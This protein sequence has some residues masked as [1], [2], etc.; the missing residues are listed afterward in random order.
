L[1]QDLGKVMEVDNSL[2]HIYIY[3]YIYIYIH[4][5]IYIYIDVDIDIDTDTDMYIDAD[6][7]GYPPDEEESVYRESSIVYCLEQEF[8]FHN[9][10]ILH[11]VCN[12]MFCYKYCSCP[13]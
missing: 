11:V 9:I 1:K 4:T 7:S 10:P 2:I 12:H 5:Y 3:T 8:L 6:A 13:M